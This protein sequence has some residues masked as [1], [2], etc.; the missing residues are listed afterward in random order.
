MM[1]RLAGI[2]IFATAV[3]Q[4]SDYKFS[5]MNVAATWCHN[6][7]SGSYTPWTLHKSRFAVVTQNS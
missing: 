2:L 5:T 6:N 1:V 4:A 3:V 7:D